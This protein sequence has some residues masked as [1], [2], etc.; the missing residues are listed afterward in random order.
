MMAV[1]R[2]A[3]LFLAAA[4]AGGCAS[5][6]GSTLAE[7]FVKPG[8]PADDF[9]GPTL[10]A[11]TLQERMK[12]IRHLSARP[13]LKETQGVRPETAD[14]RLADALRLDAASSTADSHLRVAQEYL[15]LG[16]L[17]TAYSYTNR[18]LQQKPRF[19]EAHEVMARIWR[20]WGLPALGLGP[21][22]RAIYF[23][24]ASASARNT[25]GTLLDALGQ[26]AE[27]REA[28]ARA[29]AIDPNA[30]W[31]L[32]NLCF[33][34][35]RLGRLLDARSHCQAALN[36]DPALVA[37]RNNLALTFVA[38]GDAAAARQAL[39]TGDV[40]AAAYNRGIIHMAG[41]AYARAAEAFAEAIAA[42]PNFTAAKARAHE[43]RVLTI[44]SSND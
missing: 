2:V 40:A 24:P 22:S 5:R 25:L 32:N 17:D 43:A 1:M 27:A 30:A 38:S 23:D 36:L 44:T 14:P 12:M 26:P 37:A 20:S 16:I 41:H 3:V 35:L 21:A 31:A 18:T 29:A 33:V 39:A 10:S 11:D 28:F 34:E 9:G 4:L 8:K 6:S 15:R 42:R 13:V 7:K 19:A